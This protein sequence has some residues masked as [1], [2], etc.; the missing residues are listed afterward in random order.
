MNCVAASI[1]GGFQ[2]K[3]ARENR[4]NKQISPDYLENRGP[5]PQVLARDRLPS[6]FQELTS[7]CGCSFRVG[8][9]PGEERTGKGPRQSSTGPLSSPPSVIPFL[10]V[11]QC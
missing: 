6:A 8:A 1:L 10:L 11:E 5:F 3:V 2:D 4:K 7:Q 9:R